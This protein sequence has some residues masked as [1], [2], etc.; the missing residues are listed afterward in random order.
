MIFLVTPRSIFALTG[1]GSQANPYRINDYN[2]LK[3]FAGKVNGGKVSARAELT[4]D[5]TA[6]D[7][8][9]CES[10]M[11]GRAFLQMFMAADWKNKTKGDYDR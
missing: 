4:T 2:D 11:T 1:D 7:D 10:R 3:E 6:T 8:L 9:S 5:I